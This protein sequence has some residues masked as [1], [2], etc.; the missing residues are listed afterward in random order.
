MRAFRFSQSHV[1][2]TVVALLTLALVGCAQSQ[3]DLPSLQDDTAIESPGPGQDASLAPSNPTSDKIT[4]PRTQ[5]NLEAKYAHLDP[6]G[7]IDSKL[8]STALSYLSANESKFQN[9]A[10]ITIID[11]A[12]RSSERRLFI[13]DMKSG[14]VWAMPVA[15]G[16]GSDADADGYATYFSNQSG[17]NS[18]SLGVYRGAETYTGKNG[19]SLRM[20]GLSSSNSN[21]RAR[22]V[23]IHGAAYVRDEKVIQGRSWGCPAVPMPYRDKVMAILKGGS[24]IYAGLSAQGSK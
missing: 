10:F 22:A 18:S 19:L 2:T 21:A 11:F 23:V 6:S 1:S 3:N 7:L 14:A 24:F 13:I 16:K 5:L 15:H 17:S 20:D 4:T 8:L 12:K 9:K